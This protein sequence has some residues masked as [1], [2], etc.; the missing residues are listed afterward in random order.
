MWS[1]PLVTTSGEASNIAEGTLWCSS[2]RLGGVK[3]VMGGGFRNE[4]IER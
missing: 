1:K 3:E 2:I 4:I